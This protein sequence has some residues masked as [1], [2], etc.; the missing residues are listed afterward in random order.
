MFYF[1]QPASPGADLFAATSG[2]FHQLSILLLMF[3][4]LTAIAIEDAVAVANV[5]TAISTVNASSTAKPISD[6]KATDSTCELRTAPALVLALYALY[7][8]PV[9][10]VDHCSSYVAQVLLPTSQGVRFK[11]NYIKQY[12]TPN[13][14]VLA[15]VSALR[16]YVTVVTAVIAGHCVHQ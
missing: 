14:S 9:I 10:N 15:P 2:V 6:A 12:Q 16:R 13:R 3:K 11:L 8:V 4:P 1:G 7:S 5:S